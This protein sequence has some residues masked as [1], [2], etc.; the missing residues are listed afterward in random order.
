MPTTIGTARFDQLWHLRALQQTSSPI[1]VQVSYYIKG[2]GHFIA[3]I[4]K[5]DV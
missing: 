4:E 5:D 1:S 3:T 2:F